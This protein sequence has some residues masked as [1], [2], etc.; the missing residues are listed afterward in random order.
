LSEGIQDK[1]QLL[2]ASAITL[3]KASNKESHL[4]VHLT[5]GKNREIRRMFESLSSEVTAL[6]RIAF[7]KLKL[8]ELKPGEFREV[9][10]KEII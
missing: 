8:G 2:K 3:R 1:G 4:T 10:P 9:T 6:K 7:G 5:E